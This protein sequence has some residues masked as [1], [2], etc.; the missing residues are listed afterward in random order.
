MHAC[1]FHSASLV[2]DNYSCAAAVPS[3]S[4]SE[5]QQ[6]FSTALALPT[7]LPQGAE[8]SALR[9]LSTAFQTALLG[10]VLAAACQALQ[11]LKASSSSLGLAAAGLT[12]EQMQSMRSRLATADQEQTMQRMQTDHAVTAAPNT[13]SEANTNLSAG[14]GPIQNAAESTS[15][16]DLDNNQHQTQSQSASTVQNPS[17]NLQWQQQQQQQQ[18]QPDSADLLYPLEPLPGEATCCQRLLQ[19]YSAAWLGLVPAA[20]SDRADHTGRSVE[21]LPQAATPL[22]QPVGKHSKHCF[23]LLLFLI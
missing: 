15:T 14:H 19:G 20:M 13:S 11:G 7:L 16:S 3:L 12:F 6:A 2:P 21:Q 18:E 22:L 17:D 5:A 23:G 8:A 10:P 4:A 9:A 1:I